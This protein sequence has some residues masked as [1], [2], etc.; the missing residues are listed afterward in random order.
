MGS[1]HIWPISH[2]VQ[3]GT[4]SMNLT[5]LTFPTRN[6]TGQGQLTWEELPYDLPKRVGKQVISTHYVDANLHHGLVLA[7]Q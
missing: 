5:M 3:S 2:M 7:R 4:G 1:L 6:R